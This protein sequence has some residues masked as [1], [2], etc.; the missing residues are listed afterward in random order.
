MTHS[1]LLRDVSIWMGIAFCTTQHAIIPGLH[2]PHAVN[3]EASHFLNGQLWR[4]LYGAGCGTLSAAPEVGL[5]FARPQRLSSRGSVR[6][7]QALPLI[8]CTKY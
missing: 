1:P 2:E 5:N 3:L 7:S 4:A 8:S 6:V